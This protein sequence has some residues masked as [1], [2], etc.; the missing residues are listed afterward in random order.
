METT[1]ANCGKADFATFYDCYAPAVFGIIS[2]IITNE[3]LAESVLS[4]C[5]VTAWNQKHSFDNTKSTLFTWLINLTR[6]IAFSEINLLADKTKHP[7][8]NVYTDKNTYEKNNVAHSS[9]SGTVILAEPPSKT[10]IVL[11]MIFY[12]G[13]SYEQ[14]SKQLKIPV[15]EIAITIR[16]AV[17][18]S[19]EL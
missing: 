10:S 16:E 9:L 15:S 19:K 5:F 18:N 17:K 14:V 13:M 11:E 8:L 1:F 2:K 7:L 4:N 6:K 3:E 12:K